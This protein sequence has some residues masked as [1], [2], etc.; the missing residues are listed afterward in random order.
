MA[1]AAV[2]VA[3]LVKVVKSSV[4]ADI[5]ISKNN[6][7]GCISSSDDMVNHNSNHSSC[8][9]RS[10][11]SSITNKLQYFIIVKVKLLIVI[12]ASNNSMNRK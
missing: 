11:Q 10:N 6:Y 12:M 4:I 7:T 8:N 1:I 5:V 9:S 2:I 3:I